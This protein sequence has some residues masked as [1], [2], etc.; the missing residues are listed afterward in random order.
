MSCQT[1]EAEDKQKKKE[2]KKSLVDHTYRDYSRAVI[3]DLVVKSSPSNKEIFPSKLHEILS[4]PE[5]KDI[6]DWRPHGRAWA[7]KD[8]A[9]F[10]SVVLPKFFNHSSFSSFNRSVNGW[11]FKVGSAIMNS[12][13]FSC[14]HSSDLIKFSCL[15]RISSAFKSMDQTKTHITMSSSWPS[16]RSSL[17][18]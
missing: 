5:Y 11:G 17:A 10:I 14:A 3:S 15:L 18:R 2:I 7:V 8:R 16:G 12:C 9:L 1:A 4:K 6:I 13:G